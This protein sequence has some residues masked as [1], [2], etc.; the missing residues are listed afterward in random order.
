MKSKKAPGVIRLKGQM[1][2]I[3]NWNMVAFLCHP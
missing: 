3:T 1:K 2:L